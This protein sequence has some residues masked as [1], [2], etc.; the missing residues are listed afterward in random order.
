[1]FLTKLRAF[2]LPTS[3]EPVE[4]KPVA[5]ASFCKRLTAERQEALALLS[6]RAALRLRR[7]FLGVSLR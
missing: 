6:G 7:A 3:T 2:A 5:T 1:M 4:A